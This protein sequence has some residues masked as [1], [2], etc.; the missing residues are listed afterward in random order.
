MKVAH[1]RLHYSKASRYTA[2]SCTDLD[3]ARFWI[4]SKKPWDARFWIIF[5]LA[6]RF[7]TILHDFARNFI[8]SNLVSIIFSAFK[9][10]LKS[11]HRLLHLRCHNEMKS[12]LKKHSYSIQLHFLKMSIIR[13]RA[14]HKNKNT[15]SIISLLVL[16]CLSLN[17]SSYQSCPNKVV[18]ASY[19]R[20][21]S[22]LCH[23]F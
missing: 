11:Q 7:C 14:V 18:L 15:L 23:S 5:T 8:F 22:K 2:S 16:R 4:G 10:E 6:A 17:I 20:Q 12:F 21:S 13:H 9:N 19:R 1:H 3:S